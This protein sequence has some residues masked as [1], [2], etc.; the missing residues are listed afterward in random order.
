MT[1]AHSGWGV[2]FLDFD[3]DGR[4]DL[5]IAQGHDLD[6]IELDHP[7]LHYREPMLLARN[8]GHGF[9]DVSEQSGSVFRQAK[10]ARGMAISDLDKDV[11]LDA[12][13]APHDSPVNLLHNHAPPLHH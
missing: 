13:V 12:G 4:K 10:V 6:T 9:V 2:R 1:M 8:T 3:N 7:N 5:L 11:L